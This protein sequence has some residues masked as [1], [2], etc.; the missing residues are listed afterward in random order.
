MFLRIKIRFLIYIIPT[1]FISC[2]HKE[3]HFSVFLLNLL[4]LLSIT[5]IRIMKHSGI[6]GLIAL[7]FLLTVVSCKKDDSGPYYK[8]IPLSDLEVALPHQ[9]NILYQVVDKAG[10]GV[11]D[12]TSADFV[13]KENGQ[14]VGLESQITVKQ[15]EEVGIKVRTILLLDNSVSIDSVRADIKEAAITLIN[16]K[17]DYQEIAI[18]VFSSTATLLQPLTADKQ[19]LIDAINSIDKSTS[20][21]ST[22]LYGALV[23]ATKLPIWSEHFSMDSIRTASLIC[24]SDGD[25]T[26]GS[27]PK[28]TALDSLKNK[29]VYMLGL[30]QDLNITTMKQLG[31][32]YPAKDITKLEEVFKNIH[33]DIESTANSYYWLYYQ[34]PK[35]GP[36]THKLQLTIKGNSNSGSSSYIET[37]FSSAD[38]ID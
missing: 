19:K 12:L 11:A 30:G 36:N 6:F 20:T 22:N 3:F 8:I 1:G 5:K 33:N 28:Q 37:E 18:M 15:S 21:S 14:V 32:Y 10:I 23:A 34:S 26:Q 24:L 4:F 2:Y 27:M 17:P 31:A 9:V 13:I 29:R 38:F 16:L 7:A 35:R 25:D